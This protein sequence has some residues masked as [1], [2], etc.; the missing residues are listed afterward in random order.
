MS[1]SFFVVNSVKVV[2][3]NLIS[4]DVLNLVLVTSFFR[5]SHPEADSPGISNTNL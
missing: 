1:H 2:D 3:R 4:L 5:V